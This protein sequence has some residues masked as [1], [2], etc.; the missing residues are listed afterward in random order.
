M[1]LDLIYNSMSFR[2]IKN[3]PLF[4]HCISPGNGFFSSRLNGGR[5]ELNSMMSADILA[6]DDAFLLYLDNG[7]LFSD[8][9]D[10]GESYG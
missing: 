3:S 6:E 4:G 9:V 5:Y 2:Q 10:K 7:V 1:V 8:K